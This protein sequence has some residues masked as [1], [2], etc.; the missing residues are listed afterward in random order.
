MK[1]RRYAVLSGRT[2]PQQ[3]QP[4]V[5]FR[6]ALTRGSVASRSQASTARNGY[7]PPPV[8]VPSTSVLLVLAIVLLSRP[9]VV[10]RADALSLLVADPALDAPA[11]AVSGVA[12]AAAAAAAPR[13]R[14]FETATPKPTM[15]KNCQRRAGTIGKVRRRGLR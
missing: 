14:R 4:R 11:A 9:F 12:A 15:S 13:R 10:K 1:G 3:Q 8:G 7:F 6:S 2:Q 5:R